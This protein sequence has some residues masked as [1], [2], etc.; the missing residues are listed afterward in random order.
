M[1]LESSIDAYERVLGDQMCCVQYLRYKKMLMMDP[2]EFL[3]VKYSKHDR[4]RYIE[5]S[6][7]ICLPNV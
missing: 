2:R 6:K 3:Y 7:S 1:K 5:V 4:G